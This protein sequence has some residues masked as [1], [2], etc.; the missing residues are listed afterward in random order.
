M[1]KQCEKEGNYSKVKLLVQK[2][3]EYSRAEQQRQEQNMKL[4][5]EK[6]LMNVENVQKVQFLEFSDAWDKYMKDYELTA[7]A[8]ID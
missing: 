7:F 4:A 2:F 3:D 5:Q 8:L 1:Q 6:E